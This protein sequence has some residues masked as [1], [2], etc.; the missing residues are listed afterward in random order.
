VTRRAVVL[1]ALVLSCS[2]PSET[3][4]PDLA[5]VVDLHDNAIRTS[6]TTLPA[7]RMV[8][9]VRNLGTVVHE[10]EIFRTDAPVD[11][12]PVDEGAHTAEVEGLVKEIEDIPAGRQLTTTVNFRP[13]KYVL[14]CNVPL[15]YQ[16]GMRAALTV[17]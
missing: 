7:G 1:A 12:L 11:A 9:G 13:G 3:L 5:L 16:L 2:L 14:I 10:L 6:V 15:H 17:N 4:P 8:I